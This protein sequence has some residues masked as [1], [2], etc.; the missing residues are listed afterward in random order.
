MRPRSK[1]ITSYRRTFVKRSSGVCQRSGFRDYKGLA[2]WVSSLGNEISDH[3]R[4]RYGRTLRPGAFGLRIQPAP[5][6]ASPRV[7]ADLC[8]SEESTMA[9]SNGGL[10]SGVLIRHAATHL[11]AALRRSPQ[12][13]RSRARWMVSG[14]NRQK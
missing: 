6:C 1:V 7:A 12:T 13:E 14:A 3:C 5:H 4:S 8:A 11:D 10:F 2:Q 9:F